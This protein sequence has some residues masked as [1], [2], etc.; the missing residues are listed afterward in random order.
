MR[1]EFQERKDKESPLS[2]AGPLPTL[3]HL[4]NSGFAV[5]LAELGNILHTF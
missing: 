4:Q 3:N 2:V 1:I 5:I